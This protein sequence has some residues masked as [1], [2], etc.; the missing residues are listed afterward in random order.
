MVL[1][2]DAG[3]RH[4]SLSQVGLRR[5]FSEW[6]IAA[7]TDPV[8]CGS[9]TRAPNFQPDPQNGAGAQRLSAT[10]A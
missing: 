4:A 6:D 3:T 7:E 9:T 1:L 2:G 5:Y 8:A 10:E